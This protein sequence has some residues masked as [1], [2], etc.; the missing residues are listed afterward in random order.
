MYTSFCK[1]VQTNDTTA[2]SL[3]TFGKGE[4]IEWK[5]LFL[6]GLVFFFKIGTHPVSLMSLSAA[7][8]VWSTDKLT[9]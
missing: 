5:Q 2:G 4:R 7:D 3:V 9:V 1:L 6:K 8:F